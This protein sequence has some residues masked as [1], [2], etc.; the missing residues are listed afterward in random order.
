MAGES[1]NLK[2]RDQ[3]EEYPKTHKDAP[4][5][6][7][8]A[9]VIDPDIAHNRI[10]VRWQNRSF[11]VPLESLRRAIIF[12]CLYAE[13]VFSTIAVSGMNVMQIIRDTIEELV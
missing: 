1:M 12:M 13:M 3:V 2:T 6:V 7:G 5:W 9:D 8:P 4:G 10:A 11:D